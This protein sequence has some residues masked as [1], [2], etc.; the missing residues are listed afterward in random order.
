[1]NNIDFFCILKTTKQPPLLPI[2][3]WPLDCIRSDWD[4]SRSARKFP[5][6]C[7]KIVITVKAKDLQSDLRKHSILCNAG[8]NARGGDAYN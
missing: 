8:K 1:L 4:Q 3:C 2:S 6:Q 7:F 5:T